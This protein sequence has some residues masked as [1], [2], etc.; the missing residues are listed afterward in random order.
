MR[1]LFP[2]VCVL[3]L[4]ALPAI[5][6]EYPAY[7]LFCGYGMVR[8]E[9]GQAN[10]NGWHAS[11]ASNV[12]K[13]FG[14]A[15]E[16]SGQYGSQTIAVGSGQ[17]KTK[18]DFHSLGFGP[19]LTYRKS[20]RFSPFA[21]ALFGVARGNWRGPAAVAGEETSFGTAFGGGIDTKIGANIGIR[22]IQAEYVR[23]HFGETS[24]ENNFRIAA[25]LLLSF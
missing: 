24:A 25:G 21:H 11:F 14:L 4:A 13:W 18:V 16:V 1:K 12:N 5:A 10:L 6:Q 20:E 15:V 7:E 2:A 3:S 9:G 23:T 17:F 22:L 19:R 8:T